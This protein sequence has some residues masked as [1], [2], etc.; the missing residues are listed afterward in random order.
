MNYIK[1][2]YGKPNDIGRRI[3]YN[4]EGGIIWSEGD[5]YIHANMDKDKTGVVSRIHP[6]D[7]NL[8]YLEMGKPREMPKLTR[9]QQNYQDYKNSNYYEAGDSFACYMGWSK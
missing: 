4:G 7:E 3:T 2:H 5:N 1:E 9:S 8:I 6:S